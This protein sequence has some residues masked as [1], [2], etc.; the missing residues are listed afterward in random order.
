M[1]HWM[2]H[3]ADVIAEAEYGEEG[4]VDTPDCFQNQVRWRLV[5]REHSATSVTMDAL[6]DMQLE[7]LVA[8]AAA[9]QGIKLREWDMRSTVQRVGQGRREGGRG[10]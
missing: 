5:W 10:M 7:T 2:N 8:A 9:E 4:G 6:D 3:V 1:L